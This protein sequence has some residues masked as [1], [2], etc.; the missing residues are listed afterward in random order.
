MSSEA[1]VCILASTRTVCKQLYEPVQLVYAHI[2]AVFLLLSSRVCILLQASKSMHTSRVLYYVVYSV[3]CQH[4]VVHVRARTL[5][6]EMRSSSHSLL[7]RFSSFLCL[8]TYMYTYTNK[9]SMHAQTKAF[10]MMYGTARICSS[11]NLIGSRVPH[12]APL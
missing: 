3:H 10:W 11:S 8:H 2:I 1:H 7:S 12:S 5:Y 4:V 6:V 9:M